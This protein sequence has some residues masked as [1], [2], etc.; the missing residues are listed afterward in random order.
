[1]GMRLQGESS[2][3]D[4]DAFP[5]ASK[6]TFSTSIFSAMADALESDSATASSGQSPFGLR[7][8]TEQR[9]RQ[10]ALRQDAVFQQLFHY[11][12]IQHL[13]LKCLGWGEKRRNRRLWQFNRAGRLS[14]AFKGWSSKA[15]KPA[16]ACS[17]LADAEEHS[18]LQFRRRNKNPWKADPSVFLKGKSEAIGQLGRPDSATSLWA[19]KLA[20]NSFRPVHGSQEAWESGFLRIFL[21]LGL[22]NK[23]KRAF[24]DFSFF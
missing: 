11:M 20:K 24:V 4:D 1:M 7:L 16:G 19:A 21:I 6:S 14:L 10:I 15:S 13:S 12:V 3:C 22:T 2:D 23:P 17:C 18:D 8:D 9:T 5:T